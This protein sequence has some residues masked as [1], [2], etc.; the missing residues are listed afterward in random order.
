[1]NMNFFLLLLFDNILYIVY[2]EVHTIYNILNSNTLFSIV[3]NYNSNFLFKK[4]E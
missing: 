3:F 4:N 1:M 2:C